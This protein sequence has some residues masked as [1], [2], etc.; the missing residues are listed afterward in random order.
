[1]GAAT[2]AFA[3]SAVGA[4]FATCHA[5]GMTTHKIVR[6][7]D[8]YRIEATT[9]VGN[10]WLLSRVYATEEAAKVRLNR[11]QAMAAADMSERDLSVYPPLHC[12]GWIVPW[13]IT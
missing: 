5:P 12:L 9:P 10:H 2:A 13:K 1:M 6:Q 3:L 8:V 4:A 7:A 11:L